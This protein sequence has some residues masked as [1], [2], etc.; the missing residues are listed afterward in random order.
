[1]CC[2]RRF[3]LAVL[4]DEPLEAARALAPVLEPLLH[5]DRHRG[6]RVADTRVARRVQRVRLHAVLLEVREAV[7]ELPERE[8]LALGQPAGLRRRLPRLQLRP[9][10]AV[11]PAAAVEHAVSAQRAQ[12]PRERLHLAHRVVLV[13]VR[14]PQLRA[15][16]GLQLGARVEAGGA[17]GARGEA[18]GRLAARQERVRLGEQVWANAAREMCGARGGVARDARSVSM[19]TT[20]TRPLPSAPSRCSRWRSTT[21]PAM[22]A[23][24]ST[25]RW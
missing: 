19:N 5:G 8:R 25:G 18:E 1:M 6:V 15:V 9:L 16:D 20:G 21:S 3:G 4:G 22:R 17:E 24:V 2:A 12:R 7:A 11:V 13:H 14:L 23:Q 10:E